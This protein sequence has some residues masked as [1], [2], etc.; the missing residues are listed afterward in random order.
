LDFAELEACLRK[1][2]ARLDQERA[3]KRDLALLRGLA[4]MPALV[5]A[6]AA[7]PPAAPDPARTSRSVDLVRKIIHERFS[8]NLTV[9]ALA[10][11]VYLS[12]TYLCMLF[13]QETGCTINGYLT[14]VRME[15]AKEMLRDLNNKLYDICYAVG[16]ANPSYFTR[17]FK[18][19]TGLLP[20]VFRNSEE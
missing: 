9:E 15:R 2:T 20:S 10:Q 1:V 5:P 12:P 3:V 16:Y 7:L 18:K 11:A 13:H 6:P 14:A 4:A 19:Y 8:H 17:Q